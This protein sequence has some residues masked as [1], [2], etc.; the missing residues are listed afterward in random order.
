MLK[1]GPT[2]L[3]TWSGLNFLLAASI[4]TSVVVFNADSLWVSNPAVHP[5]GRS[6][7]R[8]QLLPSR[9]L[10]MSRKIC[11]DEVSRRCVEHGRPRAFIPQ[12]N[13]KENP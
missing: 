3:S 1:R 6:R 10:A 4:L 5:L 12:V 2:V 9:W 11:C 8:S 13:Q 7:W